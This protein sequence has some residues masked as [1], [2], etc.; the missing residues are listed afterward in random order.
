MSHHVDESEWVKHVGVID[1][2]GNVDAWG[3]HWR[4][5]S[6]SVVFKVK[7]SFVNMYSTSSIPGVHFVD[8]SDDFERLQESTINILMWNESALSAY[9]EMVQRANLAMEAF[10][11]TKVR[12]RV[13]SDLESAWSKSSISNFSLQPHRS[14]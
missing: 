10:A 12:S 5:K 1:N 13:V 9:E 3:F 6:G 11:Y 8:V 2:D 4:L 7:T 14:P